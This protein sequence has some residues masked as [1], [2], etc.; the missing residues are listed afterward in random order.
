MQP[1][2]KSCK[3]LQNASRCFKLFCYK[4]LRNVAKC[5]VL[6]RS[7]LCICGWRPHGKN[8]FDVLATCWS[9]CGHWSGLIEADRMSAGLN[10]SPLIGPS[11][12]WR[13]WCA[14]TGSGF[15]HHR[16]STGYHY[17]DFALTNSLAHSGSWLP[18]DQAT[19]DDAWRNVSPRDITAQT[20]RASLFATAT[21]TTG[22]GRRANSALVHAGSVGLLRA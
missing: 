18:R 19:A 22:A 1:S 5:F 16:V 8:F 9:G 21:V 3:V 14:S 11:H 10:G 17:V 15:P 6:T 20:I 12:C 2:S 13:A 4:M 7:H